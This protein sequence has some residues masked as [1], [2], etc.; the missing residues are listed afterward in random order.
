MKYLVIVESP[1]K[2]KKI[3]KYLN[4]N[5]DINAYEV[6]ATM[7]H[8]RELKSLKNIDISNGFKCKYELITSKKSIIKIIQQKIKETNE[9]I[10]ACDMDREGEAICASICDVFKLNIL[11]TKRIIFNEIT[12]SAILYAIKR[13]VCVNLNLVNAQQTRQILDLLLGFKISP[14]LW[15]NITHTKKTL[16]AGRCQTPALKLIYDNYKHIN[17]LKEQMVYK[18]V[19]Y[20]TNL[21]IP[22]ELNVNYET[23]AQV[24]DFLQGVQSFR[25]TYECSKPI[26]ASNEPPKPFTT[27]SLQQTASN[28]LHYS[29]S[30]TMVYCQTLYE[31]GYITYIRTDSKRYSAN[32]ICDI[33]KYIA[34]KYDTTYFNQ[35]MQITQTDS[36]NDVLPHEAIRPTDICLTELPKSIGVKE[37]KLYNIIWKRTLESCMAPATFYSITVTITSYNNTKFIYNCETPDFEGWQNININKQLKGKVKEQKSKYFN[38]LQ[39]ITNNNEEIRY[40]YITANLT[41]TGRPLHYTEAKLIQLLEERGIGRP[42]TYSSIIEKNKDREYVKKENI[43]GTEIKCKNYELKDNKITESVIIRNFG[44][45]KN[46]LVIQELGINVIDF[47]NKCFAKIFDYNYTQQMEDGLDKISKG[48]ESL[49]WQELCKIYNNEIDELINELNDT[50]QL[51]MSATEIKIDDKNSYIIGK[52]GPVVKCLDNTNEPIFKSIKKDIEIDINKLENGL[53][54]IEDIIDTSKKQKK[55]V[56][57]KYNGEDVIIQKGKFGLYIK[58]GDKSRNLKEFGNRP[59][60]NIKFEEIQRYLEEGGNIVR[61]ITPFIS[62]RK[63]N[64]GDYLFYKTNKMKKPHFYDIQTFDGDYKICNMNTLKSWINEK[65]NIY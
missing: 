2:C 15:N 50:K 12:E 29:P 32:F 4:D 5:D 27:S 25:H 24:R 9:V 23:E 60:E 52:Y 64:T 37:Q 40:N 43:K 46:K 33:K 26:K 8:I 42:S 38:Y 11:T 56:L 19:G 51:E 47:L 53:L 39:N 65:Y 3:A 58:W 30:D 41:L 55:C 22:F 62:I 16:S 44:E 63:S 14:I 54:K 57:G 49:C 20:F 59:I 45:E 10:L 18:T 48:E 7:G 17:E 34:N 36:N 31:A 28:E 35:Q 1:T 6:V 61:E 13:P 21:N